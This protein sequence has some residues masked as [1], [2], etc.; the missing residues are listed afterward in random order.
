V[1]PFKQQL[2]EVLQEKNLTPAQVYNAD[3]TGLYWRLLPERTLADHTEKEAPGF[4]KQKE[5]IT[6]MACCNAD[7]SHKLPL[8]IIG[9]S[10]SPRCLKDVNI[11]Q[12]IGVWYRN[13]KSAW[14]SAAIFK[15]WFKEEFVPKVK[16]SL[17]K[18][19]L[20][21]VPSCCWTTPPPTLLQISSSTRPG[22]GS[23]LLCFFQPTPPLCCSP[24]TKDLLRP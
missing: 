16:S 3:E 1:D 9:K 2:Q 15:E 21:S 17:K 6:V 24:W 11:T 5:R 23:S 18:Q 20:P 10:K 7:G 12:D 13:Q 14:M 19:N 22:M 4:K 8:L